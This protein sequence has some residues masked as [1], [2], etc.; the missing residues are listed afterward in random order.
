M[1]S[2]CANN[3]LSHIH[4]KALTPP[5]SQFKTFVILAL[6][7]ILFT[8][9]DFQFDE[10][11]SIQIDGIQIAHSF[12]FDTIHFGSIENSLSI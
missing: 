4:Q 9:F 6:P 7:C 1:L 2:S 3:H 11:A 10:I 12:R 8:Q 5:I